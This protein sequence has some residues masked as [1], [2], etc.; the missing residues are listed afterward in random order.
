VQDITEGFEPGDLILYRTHFVEL[1]QLVR[2]EASA[3]TREFVEWPVLAHLPADRDFARRALPYSDNPQTREILQ[4]IMNE[5]ATAR[6]IWLV[7]LE[8][9]DSTGEQRV[10]SRAIRFATRSHGMRMVGRNRYG[11]VH[12]VLLRRPGDRPGSATR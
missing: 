3:S 11:L 4:S 8:V 12:V 10:L 7:G 1:D 9:D 5:A 6:G 2:G